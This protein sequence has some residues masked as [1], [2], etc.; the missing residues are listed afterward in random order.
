MPLEKWQIVATLIPQDATPNKFGGWRFEDDDGNM[1][2][3]WPDSVENYL[4]NCRI[5]KGKE[6]IALDFIHNRLFSSRFVEV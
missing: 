2:D 5:E 6:V 1:I 4:R 3:V